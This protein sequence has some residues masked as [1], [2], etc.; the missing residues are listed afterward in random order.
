MKV[1]STGQKD[2]GLGLLAQE[3][4]MM[5]F[6]FRGL[7]NKF[8]LHRIGDGVGVSDVWWTAEHNFETLTAADGTNKGRARPM[9][10]AIS[11]SI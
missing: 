7:S 2:S 1:V 9:Q 4:A 11:E 8:D 3:V 10:D 5:S 6:V